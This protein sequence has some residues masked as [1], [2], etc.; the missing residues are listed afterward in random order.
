MTSSIEPTTVLWA[1]F[2]ALTTTFVAIDWL[3]RWR[4][5]R[6][7]QH[8]KLAEATIA[9]D[10]VPKLNK[11]VTE[12]FTFFI[13]GGDG[14]SLTMRKPYPWRRFLKRAL[15]NGSTI[16]Y[17]LTKVSNGDRHKFLKVKAELEE[18]AKGKINF[19]IAPSDQPSD[20]DS[21]LIESFQTFH[22]AVLAESPN[23]RLMWIE[24][25]HPPHSTVAYSCEFVPPADAAT[26]QRYDL[27][28]TQLVH[29]IERPDTALSYTHIN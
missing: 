1:I 18:G 7:V 5:R 25:Y 2:F 17:I 19:Y 29:L 22:P 26:D 27:Y 10:L 14:Y 8:H 12:P 9:R 4:R 20:P 21:E 15:W 16:H 23:R 3:L 24:D 11:L 13:T 6:N 28:K